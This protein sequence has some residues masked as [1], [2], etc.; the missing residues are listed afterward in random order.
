MDRIELLRNKLHAALSRGDKKE[1][2]YVSQELDKEIVKSMTRNYETKRMK[3]FQ[4]VSGS[5]I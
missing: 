1:I 2:L 4:P 5:Y 3:V